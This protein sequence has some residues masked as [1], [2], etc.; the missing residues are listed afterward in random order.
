MKYFA[1]ISYSQKDSRL[2]DKLHRGLE[3]SRIPKGINPVVPGARKRLYP[4]FRDRDELAPGEP[5]PEALQEALL[6]S[7]RLIVLCSKNAVE[8]RWVNQEIEVFL[9]NRKPSEIVPVVCADELPENLPSPLTRL[10]DELLVVDVRKDKDGWELGLQ[11]IRS[12][13]LELPLGKIRDRDAAL[14]KRSVWILGIAASSFAVL[15]LIATWQFSVAQS[16]LLR[17]T[18]ERERADAENKRAFEAIISGVDQLTN[19]SKTIIELIA[20]GRIGRDDSRRILS[21]IEEGYWNFSKSG[22]MD[23]VRR[24]QIGI[25]F[26]KIAATYYKLGDRKRSLETFERFV[27]FSRQLAIDIPQNPVWR[28]ALAAALLRLANERGANGDHAGR[29]KDFQEAVEVYRSIL[30]NPSLDAFSKPGFVSGPELRSMSRR[31]LAAAALM[32]A[33]AQSE[34]NQQIDVE[35]LDEAVEALEK[36]L[37]KPNLDT[38]ETSEAQELQNKLRSYRGKN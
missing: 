6:G 12:S 26:Q 27:A 14:R 1:F 10:G 13:I 37:E 11:K 30:Q 36:E 38:N 29:I 34:G 22:E 2:S 24:S 28:S 23:E 19:S 8:S 17:E 16:A 32:L 7:H 9:K 3:R 4:I 20:K 18:Q 21:E 5:L 35:V 25:V 15:A 31:N 33:E